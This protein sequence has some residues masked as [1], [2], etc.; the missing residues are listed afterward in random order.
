MRK[1]ILAGLMISSFLTADLLLAAETTQAPHVAF[2]SK[3]RSVDYLFTDH[4][5]VEAIAHGANY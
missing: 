5:E 1:L 2:S 3:Y 4:A